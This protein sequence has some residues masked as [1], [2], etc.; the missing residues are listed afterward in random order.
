MTA[1]TNNTFHT[2]VSFV[3]SCNN[4]SSHCSIVLAK[5]QGRNGDC[6]SLTK[7]IVTDRMGKYMFEK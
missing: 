3:P 4:F 5:M 2:I 6:V 1:M 7:D